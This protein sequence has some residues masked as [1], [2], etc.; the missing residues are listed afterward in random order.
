MKS[1]YIETTIPSYYTGR[2]PR[3]LVLAAR[4]QLTVDWWDTQRSQYELFASQIVLDETRRGDPVVAARRQEFLDGIPLLD[5]SERVIEIAE[6]ILA[7]GIIPP[8]VADDA[9][10]VACAGV[11]QMD[12]LLTWNCTHIANPHNRRRIRERL[13]RHGIEIPVICTPEELIADHDNYEP[14]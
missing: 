4:Q 5:I 10:H 13:A 11:H 14:D 3:D 2:R 9:Y 6:D 8:R 7:S 1:V 12:F